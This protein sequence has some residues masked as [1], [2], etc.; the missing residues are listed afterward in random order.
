MSLFI[1]RN[2]MRLSSY[3]QNNT[4][5]RACS[6]WMV[7]WFKTGYSVRICYNSGLRHK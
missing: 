5:N 2:A 1:T 4:A 7:M 6:D 3:C